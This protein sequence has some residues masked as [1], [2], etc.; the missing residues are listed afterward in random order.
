MPSFVARPVDFPATV[1]E[2][3]RRATDLRRIIRTTKSANIGGW[4]TPAWLGNVAGACGFSAFGISRQYG[5]Q[6]YRRWS[7]SLRRLLRHGTASAI[8][9]PSRLNHPGKPFDRTNPR[10]PPF[11]LRRRLAGLWAPGG[12][13]LPRQCRSILL[14]RPSPARMANSAMARAIRRRTAVGGFV[15]VL[16]F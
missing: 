12:S 10:R 14:L 8:F 7:S 1:G 9:S 16:L 13:L 6:Q 15:I 5:V 3:R 11:R 2:P 4:A